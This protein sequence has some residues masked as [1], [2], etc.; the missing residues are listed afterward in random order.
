MAVKMTEKA[1]Q[2][3]KEVF[4]NKSLPET[5]LIRIEAEPAQEEDKV[6]LSLRLDTQEPQEDDAVETT[7]GT[8]LVIQ[9]ELVNMLG[10][11]QLDFHEEAGFVL[12]PVQ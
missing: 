5:T 12:E 9:K 10:E 8:R 6:Q 7:Q 11:S 2:Q 4:K 1:A 3:V